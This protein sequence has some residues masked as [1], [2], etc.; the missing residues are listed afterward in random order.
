MAGAGHAFDDLF[1]DV[2]VELAHGQIVEEEQRLG[3]QGQNV[4]DAVID[5]VGANGGVDADGG[6]D[7]QFGAD[8][9]GARDQHG[10]APAL[11]VE[12]EKGAKGADAAEDAFA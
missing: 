12:G 7:F 5:E 3:A 2:G 9:I 8:A 1:D 11:Q 6:G 4:I 10:L